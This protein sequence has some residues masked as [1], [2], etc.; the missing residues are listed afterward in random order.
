MDVSAVMLARSALGLVSSLKQVHINLLPQTLI[1]HS[2]SECCKVHAKC[3]QPN[4]HQMK[5][6]DF[7][8]IFH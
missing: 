8:Y 6:F 1:P 4:F 2:H 7:V 3:L 5:V